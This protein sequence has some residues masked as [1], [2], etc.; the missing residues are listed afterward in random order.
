M[1]SGDTQVELT[2][3]GIAKPLF[4]LSL[5]VVITN[6]LQTAYNLVDMFWLG[7]VSTEALAAVSFAFP[8][9]FLLIS[10]GIGLSIAGSI[11][12]AQKEGAD[13]HE[14]AEKAA[15]QTMLYITV[16]SVGMGLLG[17]FIAEPL[18]SFLGAEADVIPLATSYLEIIALGMVF[19]FGFSVFSSLLRGYG[20]TI[21]P[22]FIMGGSV[23]LNMVLDP[24]L[25]F[26]W[27]I[28]PELGV[29]GAALASVISRGLGL[30]IGLYILFT[31]AK[32]LKISISK[33]APDL[34]FFRQTIKLGVPASIE[35][36]SRSLS[37]NAILLII[38]MFTT[39]V[40]A[41]YGIVVRIYSAVYLPGIAISRSVE[42]MTG[43]N[44][45]AGKM[46]R[47]NSANNLAAK[48]MFAILTVFGIFCVV[49]SSQIVGVFSDDPEVI[50]IGSQ[51]LTI[52][53]V[54]FGFIGITRSYT[55]GLRGAGKTAA[56]AII[57]IISL[58]LFRIPFAY[59]SLDF[60]S[61]EG[62]WWAFALS[63]I[64]GAVL[65]YLWFRRGSWKR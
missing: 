65:A 15:S 63:N 47:A 16:F 45:G 40:V 51:F 62:V 61:Y 1:L 58:W 3:G 7:R 11:L 46:E 31:G 60:L 34:E 9:I 5:P 20:D 37:V 18:V 44:I 35:L 4:I 33:M 42:T 22:M 12:V 48:Y 6:L 64:V 14:G 10:L 41:A 57:T 59:L 56:A 21:T 28:F 26:G 27:S 36:V 39:P 50:D 53:A 13:D 43:Q 17:Y 55:G 49:F 23:L 2:E 54:T 32:G 24:L 30:I 8:V 52:L 38:G 29:S 25:I 19:T